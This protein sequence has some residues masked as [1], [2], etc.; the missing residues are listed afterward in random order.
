MDIVNAVPYIQKFKKH[1]V[2]GQPLQLKDLIRCGGGVVV[3]RLIR[4]VC[5]EH[6]QQLP[7]PSAASL[8]VGFSHQLTRML[9]ARSRHATLLVFTG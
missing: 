5:V 9:H 2:T 7:S 8:A 3:W 6:A 4:R 1:P